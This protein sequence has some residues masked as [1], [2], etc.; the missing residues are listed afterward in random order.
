M[1]DI[2]KLI[3]ELFKIFRKTLSE[4]KKHKNEEEIRDVRKAIKEADIDKLRN[5]VLGAVFFDDDD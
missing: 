1:K 3:F 4:V 5:V 2:L